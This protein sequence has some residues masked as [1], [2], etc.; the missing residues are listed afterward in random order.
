MYVQSVRGVHMLGGYCLCT[1]FIYQQPIA[2]ACAFC[3]REFGGMD[4]ERQQVAG[5]AQRQDPT[6]VI[7]PVTATVVVPSAPDVLSLPVL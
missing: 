4:G 1:L 6:P 3:G 5:V 2:C 7:A